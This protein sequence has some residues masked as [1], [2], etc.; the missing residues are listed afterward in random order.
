MIGMMMMLAMIFL[1]SSEG[2]WRTTM[3]RIKP[4]ASVHCCFF[5]F[6]LP[7]NQMEN[8]PL[9]GRKCETVRTERMDIILL[10]FLKE[11]LPS[12]Y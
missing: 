10:L 5:F 3:I 9:L 11:Y 6:I 12:S 7:A 2:N 4:S 1:F 8:Y